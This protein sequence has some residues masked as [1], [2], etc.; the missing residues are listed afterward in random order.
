MGVSPSVVAQD[1]SEKVDI[2]RSNEVIEKLIE[3]DKGLKKVFDTA[4]AYAVFPSVGKGAVGVG[5]AFGNGIMF[6]DGEPIG[7]TKLSQ[8]S[9]GAQAGG[10]SFIE[11]VFLE[12]ERAFK[13]FSEDG[14]KLAAQASAVAIVA[15]GQAD[16]R[17]NDGVAI[18]TS[19]RGGLMLEAAVGGQK[20]RYRPF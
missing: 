10:Q 19:T 9:I 8:V 17:Y 14:L 12:D 2:A 4:Y 16:V 6:K 13:N 5:G 3:H 20:F 7:T 1:S 11:V 18:I 15:G